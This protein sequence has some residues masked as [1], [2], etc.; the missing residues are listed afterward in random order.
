MGDSLTC[1]SDAVPVLLHP[2]SLIA[3]RAAT[4]VLPPWARWDEFR[5]PRS[6]GSG[7]CSSSFDSR[8]SL[9]LLHPRVLS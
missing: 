7:L 8:P 3:L 5:S 6:A 4:Y 2:C 9:A 1:G